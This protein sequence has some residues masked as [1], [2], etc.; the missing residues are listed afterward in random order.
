MSARTGIPTVLGWDSHERQWGRDGDLLAQRRADVDRVYTSPSLE[1]AL[2][3][4]RQY[5]VTYVFVGRV[6]RQQYA[7]EGL[8][9]FE[10]AWP[11]VFRSGETVIYRTPASEPIETTR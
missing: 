3:I 2:A 11:A 5:D 10:A 1:E 4:L 9:K 6:E 7:V 8:L